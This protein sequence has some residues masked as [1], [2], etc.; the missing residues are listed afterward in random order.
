MKIVTKQI[1]IEAITILFV[2]LWFYTGLNKMFDYSTFKSQLDKSPFVEHLS[3]LISSILPAGEMLIGAMLVY[4]RT[5]LI[6]L[7]LSFGLMA[8]FTGYVWMMLN[9]AYDL[10]CSCGGIVSQFSWSE[11]LWFNAGF[12]LLAAIAILLI[13]NTLSIPRRKEVLI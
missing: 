8:L 4:K 12:T 11:H 2:I 1:L 13:T 6:G 3:S 10:P 5:K 9:Y 7:C